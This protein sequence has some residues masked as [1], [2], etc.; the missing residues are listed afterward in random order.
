VP[1]IGGKSLDL[2][3]LFVEVTS[4]GGLQ[5]VV[6]ERK[7]KEIIALFNFPSTI[8]SASF[9]LRKYYIS[10]LYHYEQV[11]FFRNRRLAILLDEN[12]SGGTS[13][14]SESR[15]QGTMRS[16]QACPSED[17][18]MVTGK[19]I[20]KFDHGYMVV[21]NFGSEALEGFLYHVPSETLEEETSDP[22]TCNNRHKMAKKAKS[23]PSWHKSNGSAYNFIAEPRRIL[24]HSPSGEESA[25]IRQM[26]S[27]WNN[28]TATEEVYPEQRARGKKRYSGEVVEYGMSSNP[29]QP[30]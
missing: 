8:T 12:Q 30:S 23:N 20:A 16:P 15:L 21:A 18:P 29:S 13:A 5:K 17:A 2:H 4:R 10:L 6:N 9:V 19:I 27:M 7:W 14:A 11:Y 1:R 3:R 22:D 25:V 24:N 28:L 26:D